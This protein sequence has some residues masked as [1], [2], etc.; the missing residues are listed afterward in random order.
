MVVY[1][2]VYERLL[3]WLSLVNLNLDSVLSVSCIVKT[4]FYRNL[5][6]AMT[7]PL[8]VLG[9]L[10]VTYAVAMS[11]NQHSPA[12]Q[13]TAEHKHLS[14]AV[15]FLLVIYSPVCFIIFQTFACE[16]LDNN[17]E[18]LKADYSLTCTTEFHELAMVF[19]GLMILM[20]PVGIPT[21]FA[22]W[23]HSEWKSLVVEEDITLGR[24]QPMRGLWAAYKPKH[25]YFE[26]IEFGRRLI[27]TSLAVFFKPG[28]ASHV[29]LE[30]LFSVVFLGISDR[31]APFRD[32]WDEWLYRCGAWVVFATMSFA[33]MLKV[34]VS[35]AE[36]KTFAWLLTI[37]NVGMCGMI[38]GQY[39]L[40][41]LKEIS[42]GRTIL[43]AP[44][45]PL[46]RDQGVA[47]EES[48][49]IELS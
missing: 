29:T 20:Y 6:F 1:P 22:W 34:D 49:G 8:V 10:R 9:A 33:L 25:Y 14:V 4:N 46:D 38:L 32:V 5:L 35:D 7:T 37:A 47:R 40:A 48:V 27:L 26:M 28:T 11:R 43:A 12:G 31:L 44:T 42:Q 21:V 2:E 39:M 13:K 30:M 16:T 24:L 15:F 36:S 19:A 18:Y 3:K 41:V 17:V 45:A 23:L